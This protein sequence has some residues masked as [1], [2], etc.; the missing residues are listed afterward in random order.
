MSQLGFL[1]AILSVNVRITHHHDR[2]LRINLPVQCD[3]HGA[4]IR[5]RICLLT[6][7][8]LKAGPNPQCLRYVRASRSSHP[9]LSCLMGSSCT[10]A[11]IPLQRH[12]VVARSMQFLAQPALFL[13]LNNADASVAKRPWYF[14]DCAAG[15]EIQVNPFTR[16]PCLHLRCID[17]LLDPFEVAE[18]DDVEQ[19]RPEN[20]YA[21]A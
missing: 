14:A 19:D 6:Q 1:P 11:W 15:K 5:K 16:Y 20:G 7:Q 8:S 18:E 4:F 9:S 10:Q 12:R 2:H 13:N 21:E 17:L 3:T